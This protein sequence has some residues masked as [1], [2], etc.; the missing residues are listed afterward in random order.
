MNTVAKIVSAA[1]CAVFCAAA[2]FSADGDAAS[3]SGVVTLMRPIDDYFFMR[4]DDGSDWRVSM[5]GKPKQRLKPGDLISVDGV[6]EKLRNRHTTRLFSADVRKTGR[7]ESSIPPP[8]EMTPRELWEIPEGSIVPSWYARSV[9]VTGLVHDFW[10]RDNMLAVVLEGGGRFVYAQISAPLSEHAPENFQVGARVCVRG[11]AV[12]SAKWDSEHK[13][14]GFEN[15][16]LLSPGMDSLNVLSHPPFWTPGRLAAVIGAL[17]GVLAVFGFWVLALRRAVAKQARH[18][19]KAIRSRVVAEATMRERFRLAS[20]LHDGFQQLLASCSY[21]L[22]AA[23]NYMKDGASREEILERLAGIGTAINQTQ[24]GL[25]SALWS[26]NEEADGPARFSGLVRYAA[27]RLAYWDKV[28]S[29]EF[30]GKETPIARRHAGSLLMLLQEAVA[31]AMRHG[32]ATSVRVHVEFA[33]GELVVTI[34]DNGCG[35]APDSPE[36]AAKRGIGLKGMR[37]RTAA[38]GGTFVI[39]S[40]PGKGTTIT[41]RMPL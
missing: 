24:A 20:E 11:V 39:E 25:R 6:L 22:A 3:F 16:C 15:V 7:D 35:F 27:G 41:V 13:L 12:Y 5:D 2:G 21:R 23:I 31:N 1:A 36:I 38:M 29:F 37:E 17:L 10:R 26:L 9:A 40:A 34:A 32:R 19:E 18:I 28:V 4:A 33:E 8:V 30:T 14:A